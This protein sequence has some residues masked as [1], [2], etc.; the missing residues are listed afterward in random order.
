MS[1]VAEEVLLR[2]Y[3]KVRK[4]L[5]PFLVLFVSSATIG[6]SID[7]LTETWQ[8]NLLWSVSGVLV[9]LFWLIPVVR[10]LTTWIELTNNRIVYRRGWFGTK[11]KDIS[12]FE[13]ASVSTS[14]GK[15]VVLLK[16][17]ENLTIEGF[18]KIR[19]LVADIEY[20]VRGK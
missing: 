16:S 13:I 4:L 8:I 5:L 7:R 18:G 12:Y 1:F 17:G 11:T 6:L 14:K 3:P 19:D 9:F 15:L 20:L 10:W 2:Q